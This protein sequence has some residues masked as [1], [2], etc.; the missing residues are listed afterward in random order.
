M[1]K[2]L[3]SH[4]YDLKAGKESFFITEDDNEINLFK[5]HRLL[6]K[7]TALINE[8]NSKEVNDKYILNKNK[9]IF[10]EDDFV[11]GGDNFIS[12]EDY[13]SKLEESLQLA[14]SYHANCIMG[15]FKDLSVLDISGHSHIVIKT[16]EKIM[17]GI[18]SHRETVTITSK[19]YKNLLK[20]IGEK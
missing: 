15:R 12:G 9:G 6:A 10:I 5:I 8:F 14:Y 20:N 3:K 19:E 13:V 17:T 1:S 4:R 2:K 16:I 18:V 7:F 11:E